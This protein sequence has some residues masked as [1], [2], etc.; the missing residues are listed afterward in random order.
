[1]YQRRKHQARMKISDSA[2]LA[3]KPRNISGARAYALTRAALGARTAL[4]YRIK[5]RHILCDIAAL[6]FTARWRR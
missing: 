2:M 6:R 1:M 4:Q 5:T 3:R